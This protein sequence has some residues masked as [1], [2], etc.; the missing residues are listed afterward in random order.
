MVVRRYL[1][2]A[3]GPVRLDGS[4]DRQRNGHKR[5]TCPGL[6]MEPVS[7]VAGTCAPFRSIE[8]PLRGYRAHTSDNW[9][10]AFSRIDCYNVRMHISIEP[11]A[12]VR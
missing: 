1:P 7:Q 12:P 9:M 2:K 8:E 4:C 3:S 6:E 10:S 11:I 5:L